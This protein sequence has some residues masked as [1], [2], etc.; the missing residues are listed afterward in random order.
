MV[1]SVLF[2]FILRLRVV[3]M[4]DGWCGWLMGGEGGWMVVWLIHGSGGWMVWLVDGWGR[5]MVVG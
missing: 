5:R 3:V 4:E 1:N 2:V